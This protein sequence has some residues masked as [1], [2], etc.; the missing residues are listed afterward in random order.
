MIPIVN[1]QFERKLNVNPF[2][3][4]MNFI[5]QYFIRQSNVII[6]NTPQKYTAF[7]TR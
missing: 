5:I 4:Q 1:S 7:Y 6:L 2:R 3:F